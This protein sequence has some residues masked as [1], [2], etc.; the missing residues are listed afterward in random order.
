MAFGVLHHLDD[1]EAADCI[2]F[3]HDALKRERSIHLP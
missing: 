2:Q 1:Q 3:A